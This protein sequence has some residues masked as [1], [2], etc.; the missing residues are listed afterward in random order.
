MVVIRHIIIAKYKV[1][2]YSVFL[3]E[4]G[5]ASRDTRPPLLLLVKYFINGTTKSVNGEMIRFRN[6]SLTNVDVSRELVD[7]SDGSREPASGL[8]HSRASEKGSFS[9]WL[10]AQRHQYNQIEMG[11]F[12][13]W[14]IDS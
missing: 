13:H 14:R 12:R 3:L 6:Q 9:G 7:A 11:E 8:V 5:L 2:K 1:T 4:G 10:K